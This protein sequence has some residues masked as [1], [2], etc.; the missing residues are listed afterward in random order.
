MSL[1]AGSALTE[2]YCNRTMTLP[3]KYGSH[4]KNNVI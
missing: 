3:G 2:E 4:V 1:K